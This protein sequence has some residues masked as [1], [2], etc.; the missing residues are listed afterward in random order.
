M[1][2]R[3]TTRWQALHGEPK[4]SPPHPPRPVEL[5]SPSASEGERS[6]GDLQEISTSTAKKGHLC[7]N[8]EFDRGSRAQAWADKGHQAINL[9]ETVRSGSWR[10][11]RLTQ[12]SK[13]RTTPLLPP[14][15][16]LKAAPDL[17]SKRRA[18]QNQHLLR[19][20]SHKACPDWG[21]ILQ[22]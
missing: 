10:V 5:E 6:P 8:H 19:V 11:E 16:V 9:A 14:Y 4:P 17:P 1:G 2:L 13:T 20:S 15:T 18:N 7:G 21:A 12:P 22:L 3:C